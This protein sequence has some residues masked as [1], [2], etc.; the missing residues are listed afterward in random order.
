MKN[1]K[2][3]VAEGEHKLAT[4]SDK[5]DNIFKKY[6]EVEE[7]LRKVKIEHRDAISSN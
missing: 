5:Y 6:E 7:T 4:L 3:K 2:A 1:E